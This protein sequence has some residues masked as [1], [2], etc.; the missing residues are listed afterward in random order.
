MGAGGGGPVVEGTG[1]RRHVHRGPR[2]T[3]SGTF[4]STW[5]PRRW[6]DRAANGD[7]GRTHFRRLR[8]ATPANPANRGERSDVI[9]RTGLVSDRRNALTPPHSPVVAPVGRSI[10]RSATGPVAG[11]RPSTRSLFPRASRRACPAGSSRSASSG[12]GPSR[13]P[14]ATPERQPW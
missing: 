13:E 14:A 9:W 3:A 2:A 11:F 1:E 8:P 12:Y 5:V 7:G 6:C 10:A 4:G